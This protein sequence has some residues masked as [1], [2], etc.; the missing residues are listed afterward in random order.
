MCSPSTHVESLAP[1]DA[2]RPPPRSSPQTAALAIGKRE[3]S[4]LGLV[5]QGR[6]RA[7]A[8]F[9]IIGVQQLDA[10][11]DAAALVSNRPT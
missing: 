8:G 1:I 9:W 2:C 5:T 6:L 10:V 3:V 11:D 4:E 7:R